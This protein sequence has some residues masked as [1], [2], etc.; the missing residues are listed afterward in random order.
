LD[1]PLL[2]ANL[3]GPEVNDAAVIM[4]QGRCGRRP[5]ELPQHFTTFRASP[6]RAVSLY[7]S[8]MSAPVSR[9]DLI[10][11]SRDTWC[12]PSPRTASRAAVIALIDATAFRQQ[13]AYDPVL[14]RLGQEAGRSGALRRGPRLALA[15]GGRV[16]DGLLV[17]L[18]NA[19]A[20]KGAVGD[21]RGIAAL[22]VAA[23]HAHDRP[24]P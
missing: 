12:S 4:V 21:G 3:A 19:G 7:L 24:G 20:E 2:A 16:G 17:K 14:V 6:P 9:I 5:T 22:L 15:A 8:F 1:S 11:L 13:K 10:A 23:D 18:V